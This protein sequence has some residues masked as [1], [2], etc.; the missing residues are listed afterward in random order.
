MVDL[1]TAMAAAAAGDRR[2]GGRDGD[3]KKPGGKVGTEPFDPADHVEK[4]KADTA[5]MWLVV[6]LGTIVALVMRY[7]LMP[8]MDG[9][10]SVLWSLPLLLILI[11]PTL[12]RVLL[13]MFSDRYSFSNWFRG[14]F[15]YTFT[16]LAVTFVLVNPPLADIS[17]PSIAGKMV[18]LDIDNPDDWQTTDDEIMAGVDWTSPERVGFAF[19]IRDNLDSEDVIVSVVLIQESTEIQS[20]TGTSSEL[21]GNWDNVSDNVSRVVKNTYDTPIL[22][23][24]NQTLES[25]SDYEIIITMEQEGDPWDLSKAVKH[26]FRII[27]TNS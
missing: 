2:R 25:G 5:S 15:L 10:A 14:G 18:L 6:L 26:Q 27:P 17:D 23:E 7:L 4:E 19:A 3:K 21:R 24:F 20:W 13:P 1:S 9:P 16:W 12:H 11:I 22:L 8:Q